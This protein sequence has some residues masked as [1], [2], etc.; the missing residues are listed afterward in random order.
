[1]SSSHT[2]PRVQAF[3]DAVRSRDGRCV[4]TGEVALG[5]QYDNWTGFEAAHVFPLALEGLWKDGNYGRW[6]D[7]PQDGKEIKGGKINSVQNGLLIRS[8]IRQ[9]F[10]SYNFSINPNVCIL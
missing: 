2:G 5:A 4:I 3:C 6:I 9:L 10:D 7:S 8:D 1:M